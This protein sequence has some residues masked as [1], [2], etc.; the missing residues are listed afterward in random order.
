MKTGKFSRTK[1]L[2]LILILSV[3]KTEIHN[4]IEKPEDAKKNDLIEKE[5]SNKENKIK[6]AK[7]ETIETLTK[8]SGSN[9]RT[10]TVD[11]TEKRENVERS[12]KQVKNKKTKKNKK[13]KLVKKKKSGRQLRYGHLRN[14][15]TDPNFYRRKQAKNKRINGCMIDRSYLDMRKEYFLSGSV[16][17]SNC[18]VDLDF[19]NP[20]KRLL[21]S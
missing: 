12:L 2:V 9:K 18:S 17:P 7:V 14:R 10:I 15:R 4:E 11:T 5:S 19:V 6:N 16:L 20:P 1:L 21:K 8:G 13:V 3:I